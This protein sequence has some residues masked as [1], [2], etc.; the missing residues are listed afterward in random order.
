[1]WNSIWQSIR[2]YFEQKAFQRATADAVKAVLFKFRRGDGNSVSK[3]HILPAENNTF[4]NFEDP[5]VGKS[6]ILMFPKHT[7]SL[8]K[9]TL[10]AI[11]ALQTS[12][13]RL[14]AGVWGW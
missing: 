4:C 5:N 11:W 7:Y 2:E 6:R 1:M 8:H 9:T 3:T 14:C 10:P 13:S 12:F